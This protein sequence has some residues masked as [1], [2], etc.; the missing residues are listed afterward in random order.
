M[1]DDPRSNLKEKTSQSS[2]VSNI[3][4]IVR[5]AS[6]AWLTRITTHDGDGAVGL[7]DK[8]GYDFVT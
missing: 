3:A 1:E 7:I 6:N 5:N 4:R 8:H 2:Y